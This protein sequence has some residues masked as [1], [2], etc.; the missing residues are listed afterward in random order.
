MREVKRSA[1]VARSA[2]ELFDLIA[3]IE[4][5]SDFL[6]WCD[7]ARILSGPE[8]VDPATPEGIQQVTARV[9][10]S[11][12]PLKG[13]FTTRNRIDR[14]Y[15]MIMTLVEG[16]FSSLEGHWKVEPLGEA[17]CRLEL[18]LTFEF[19]N[20]MQDM[21]LGRVFEQSCNRLVDAFVER[22]RLIYG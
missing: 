12:G 18:T 5:Y 19:S 10:L 21:V 1:L 20:P 3:D 7:D 6:P 2:E 15:N 11:Q 13:H 4:S 16:S 17:G 14:P 22:A 9:G 8:P